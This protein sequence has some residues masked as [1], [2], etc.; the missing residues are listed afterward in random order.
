MGENQVELVFEEYDF[1]GT[2][3]GVTIRVNGRDVATGGYGG[4]P[5]DNT[6]DRYYA[7][8]EGAL[9]ALA[10]ALDPHVRVT[11]ATKR[12]GE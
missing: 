10:R 6:R 5:E 12:C 9:E 8:V 7:W 11:S 2:R 3:V 4:E 1:G